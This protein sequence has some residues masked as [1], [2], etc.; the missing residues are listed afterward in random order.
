[1]R[2]WIVLGA[3]VPTMAFA[4]ELPPQNAAPYNPFPTPDQVAAVPKSNAPP[5]A[6][7]KPMPSDQACHALPQVRTPKLPVGETFDYDIDVLT[8][9]AARMEVETLPKQNGQVAVR[10]RIKT[11]TFFNKVRRVKAEAK[12]YLNPKTMKPNRYTEDAVEDNDRKVADVNF[13]PSGQTGPV[14]SIKYGTNVRPGEKLGEMFGRYSHDALD[15]LGAIYYLRSLDLK[16][17]MPLCFDVYAMRHMFRVWGKVGEVEKVST[18]AGEFQAW[19][20]EGTA[21]RLDN[22]EFQRDL[23]AWISD[24]DRRIPV[25][26]LGGID[27][28]P[29]RATLTHYGQPGNGEAAESHAQGLDW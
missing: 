28:G 23:H 6:P 7:K 5:P 20:I 27:L 13:H 10:V 11:N 19:H 25:G 2:R 22:P 12:S 17:G 29:V 9:N 15:E 18:S 14:V 1:M 21:A 4:Q 26:A 16:P 24:D 3:L 8:A